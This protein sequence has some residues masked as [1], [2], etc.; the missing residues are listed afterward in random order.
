MEMIQIAAAGVGAVVLALMF[1]QSKPEIAMVISL[2]C[3]VFVFFGIMTKITSV[4]EY[5]SSLAQNISLDPIYMTVILKM[6]GI[7]YVAEF[8]S[9]IC[10]DAGYSS[11]AG[12]LQV[13]AKISI[14]ALSMPVLLAFLSTVED[15]L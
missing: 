7:T 13:F 14:L 3:C 11:I 4:L 2:A 8:A 10:R 9:A 1:R 15:F 12:Q 6:I 5:V